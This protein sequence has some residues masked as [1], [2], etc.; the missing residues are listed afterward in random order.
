MIRTLVVDDDYRV[1]DLHAAYV[2][3]VPGFVVAGRAHSGMEAL[4]E[5]A[6]LAPDLILLDF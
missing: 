4:E 6:R 5:V 1:A 2:E 3:R